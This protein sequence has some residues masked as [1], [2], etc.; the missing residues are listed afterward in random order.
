MHAVKSFLL[1]FSLT[2]CCSCAAVLKGSIKADDVQIPV[3]FGKDNSILLVI[4]EGKRSYD[5][6]LERNFRNHYFGA[7]ELVFEEDI[8]RQQQYRDKKKYR[9][10][11]YEDKH[12]IYETRI[13]PM[14]VG[15]N[16]PS[17]Y[18]MFAV[19]DRLNGREYKTK[20]GTAAFSK[21]MRA[22]IKELEKTRAANT[23]R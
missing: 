14:E 20:H 3:N 8:E 6:Y 15:P 22:Y 23:E 1:F 7:Y 4:Q 18:A 9:Y 17:M 19:R 5:R 21:W 16:P 11:F 10:V 13:K 12:T 2:A